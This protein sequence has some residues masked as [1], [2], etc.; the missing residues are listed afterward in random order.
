MPRCNDTL[1]KTKQRKG[2]SIHKCRNA[3]CPYYR[4]RLKGLSKKERKAFK[5]NK[6]LFKMHYI[7]RDFE[8][9]LAELE[10]TPN[11]KSPVQLKNIDCSPH[12]LGLILTYHVNYGLSGE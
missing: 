5:K 4:K 7:Y 9:S 1:I 2:F 3:K 6:T 11:Y 12:V 10:D 8:L